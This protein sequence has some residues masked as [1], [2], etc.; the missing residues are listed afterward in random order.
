MTT[1]IDSTASVTPAKARKARKPKPAIP[2][3]QLIAEFDAL[4]ADGLVDTRML[5]AYLRCSIEHL[6]QSRLRGAGPNYLKL[7]KLVRYRKSDVLAWIDAGVRS[8]TSET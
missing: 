6:E 5:A 3:A 7:G 8:N 1:V 2:A 4:P